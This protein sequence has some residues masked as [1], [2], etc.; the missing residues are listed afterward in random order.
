MAS[1]GLSATGGSSFAGGAGSGFSGGAGTSSGFA[2]SFPVGGGSGGPPTGGVGGDA[3]TSSS[4]GTAGT[5]L[6]EQQGSC[7][8]PAT[9]SC[10][11]VTD[12]PELIAF[13][14]GRCMELGGAW[15]SGPCPLTSAL[16]GCCRQGGDAACYYAAVIEGMPA[17]SLCAGDGAVWDSAGS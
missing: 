4:A 11:E 10:S 1:G 16:V 14:A 6:A 13:F 5:G 8:I 2:G 12:S 17:Q 9:F 7:N 3:G 15:S